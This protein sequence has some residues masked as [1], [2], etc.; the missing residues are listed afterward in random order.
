MKTLN[1][2]LDEQMKNPEFKKH[3]EIE[4][5]LQEIALKIAKLRKTSGLSQQDLAEKL[6]TKQQVI[7]RIEAGNQN[8]SIEM[9]LKL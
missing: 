3:Y 6:G 4:T 8:I 2:F 5:I 7:S 1:E 9:L